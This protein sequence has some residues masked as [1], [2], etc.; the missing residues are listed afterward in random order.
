MAVMTATAS[1]PKVL[2]VYASTHG[3]TAKIATRIAE[4]MREWGVDVDL[5]DVEHAGAA[6]PDEYDVVVVG[7]SLHAEHHQPEIVDWV[8]ARRAALHHLPT[9]FFSVS[10]T[11][12]E[13]SA[14]ARLATQDCVDV[15]CAETGWTPGRTECIPGA[16]QYRE[17]NV[18]TRQLMRLL[19]KR[20][21]HDT[22]ASHD[23]DYTD[24]NAVDRLGR[25]IAA[26]AGV[27]AA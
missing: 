1:A 19:M 18:F 10:L 26:L 11:A 21:G 8:K 12:A 20:V 14:A 3:Y 25:E 13:D 4:S 15:F 7:A 24:W 2:V 16:L 6:E 22:D 17:Y 27:H 9:V 5:R 23:H